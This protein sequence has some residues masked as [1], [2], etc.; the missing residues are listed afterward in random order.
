MTTLATTL[1]RDMLVDFE[2]A[3]C[4]GRRCSV[5]AV[6]RAAEGFSFHEEKSRGTSLVPASKWV[7]TLSTPW[8]FGF[9]YTGIGPDRI[10][11]V[12]GREADF[13]GERLVRVPLGHSVLA[14]QSGLEAWSVHKTR[15][16][17]T[18]ALI[19]ERKKDRR[20]DVIHGP[21]AQP[22]N[23]KTRGNHLLDRR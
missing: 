20:I 11:D 8:A 3:T 7:W 6:R 14:S 9:G 1:R 4:L 21:L 19:W 5:M 17:C 22:S 16:L 13:Q 12:F 10:G 23:S 15:F 18:P 2:P